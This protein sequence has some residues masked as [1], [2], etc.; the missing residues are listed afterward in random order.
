MSQQ[1]LLLLQQQNLGLFKRW[2]TI[3]D[4]KGAPDHNLLVNSGIL[5]DLGNTFALAARRTV[6]CTRRIRCG[7][8]NRKQ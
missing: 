2:M 3:P 6:P 5:P 8:R 1:R 7:G 4:L